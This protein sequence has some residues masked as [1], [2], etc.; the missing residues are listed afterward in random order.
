MKVCAIIQTPYRDL[1]A[2]FEKRYAAAVT[3]AHLGARYP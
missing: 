3:P 2:D 1:P